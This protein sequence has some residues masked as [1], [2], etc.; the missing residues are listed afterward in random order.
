VAVLARG[1]AGLDATAKEI[2]AAGARA[3]VLS[4]DVAD[5]EAV[6][7]AAQRIERELG[8]IDIWINNAMTTIFGPVSSVTAR[9]F[10]RVTDV[11]YHGVVWGTQAALRVM[12]P[13]DRGVI[14]QVGSALAYRGIPLQAAYCA[15]KHAVRGFTDA[16]RAELLHDNSGVR[17]TMVQLPAINT[18]QH[19]WCENKL[20]RV[21]QPVP[22]I[23]QPEIAADAIYFAA[24]HVR[25]E[26]WLGWPT[27]K[28]ILGQTVVPGYVD[29]RLARDGYT[30]QLTDEPKDPA[31]LSNLFAPVPGDH[32]PYGELQGKRRDVVA[33]ASTWL[34]A[35]GVTALL[36][37]AGAATMFILGRAL[38]R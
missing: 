26:I 32:G 5:A 1:Q 13:R 11:T 10:E 35:A 23:I 17:L 8:P 9:E 7:A 38:R 21:P 24:T 31:Q 22:P 2:E 15:A 28:T 20:E 19:T 3:L 37:A 16:L 34:G 36:G 25:R 4:V 12:R 29:R 6:L 14:V 27:I 18:P 33:R 30:S